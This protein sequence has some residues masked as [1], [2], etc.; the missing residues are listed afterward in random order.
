MQLLLKVIGQSQLS[1]N[2]VLKRTTDQM[3]DTRLQIKSFEPNAHLN[4]FDLL[5]LSA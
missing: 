2:G 1:K 5:N 3:S 4:I